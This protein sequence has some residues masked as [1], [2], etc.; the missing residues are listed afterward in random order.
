MS[1]QL[2]T[3]AMQSILSGIAVAGRVYPHQVWVNSD[4]DYVKFF[5]NAQGVIDTAMI[6]RGNTQAQDEGPNNEFDYHLMVID[7]YR[8]VSRAAD[9]SI[10]S[11]DQFQL[12]VE[13]IRATFNA[14][15]KLTVAGVHNA[16]H[17]ASAMSAAEVHYVMFGGVMCHHAKLTTRVKDGPNS[18]QS[19]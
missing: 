14:N 5:A 2:I 1:L 4:V 12:D 16:P 19:A 7:K 18:T 17:L 6:T 10:N 3:A 11:E 8:A 15:R 13:T 9:D